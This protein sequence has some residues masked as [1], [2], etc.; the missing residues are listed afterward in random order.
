MGAMKAMNAMKKDGGAKVSPKTA[1]VV[2]HCLKDLKEKCKV[3]KPDKELLLK[4]VQGMGPAAFLPDAKLVSSTDPKELETVKKNFLIKKL[5]LKDSPKLDEGIEKVMTIYGK[6]NA[7]KLR[8]VVYYLLTKHFNEKPVQEEAADGTTIT[9]QG[10][11]TFH[12]AGNMNPA[13]L[14]QGLMAA[15]K[16]AAEKVVKKIT[17]APKKTAAKKVMKKITKSVKKTA[18]TKVSP[19]TQK[20][21]DECLNDLKKK[22]RVAKPD[23]ELLLKV[24][25]GMGPAAFLADAKLVSSQPWELETVKKSFLIKKLG[26]A[27]SKKL[28]AGIEKVMKIY[29]KSNRHKLRG[30]VYYLLTKH[31]GK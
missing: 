17:K 6:S 15:Q 14:M 9:F 23:E 10:P 30:V 7:H 5:G 3:A 29:G 25:K 8:G 12:L 19:K 24:V 20:A 31:F 16:P 21:V 2:D 4:V 26:L 22:C 11:L 18:A 28:D 27:D 1:E 13:S